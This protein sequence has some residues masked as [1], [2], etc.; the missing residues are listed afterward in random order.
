MLLDLALG[1]GTA[2]LDQSIMMRTVIDLKYHY[3]LHFDTILR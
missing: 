2:T 1:E 3:H